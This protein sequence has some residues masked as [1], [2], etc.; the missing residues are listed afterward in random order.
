MFNLLIANVFI[1]ILAI[2]MILDMLLGVIR[3]IKER[4]FNSSAGIDG[5][6]RKV[7]MLASTIVLWLFDQIIHIDLAFM[8][9]DRYLSFLGTNK[10]GLCE[11]FAILY[12][13]FEFCSVLKNMVK[14]GLPVPKKIKTW[15]EKALTELTDE[16]GEKQKVEVAE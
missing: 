3:A 6:I 7:G 8:I 5:G 9:P 4:K 14:C 12:I 15:V 11:I 2:F 13:M 1:K 16:M 10:I